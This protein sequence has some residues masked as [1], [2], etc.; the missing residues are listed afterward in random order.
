MN[1]YRQNNQPNSHKKL[2]RSITDKKLGG[3]CG[4]LAE[5]FGLDSTLVRVAFVLFGIFGA[6]VI[7]YLALLFVMPKPV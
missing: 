2:L 3:V 5:Y 4:G 1:N 7:V 6:G